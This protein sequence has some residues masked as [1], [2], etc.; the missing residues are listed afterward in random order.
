M[1][2]KLIN[3]FTAVLWAACWSYLPA[4]TQTRYYTQLKIVS[5][6]DRSEQKGDGSG[7]FITFNEKGCYDSDKDGYTVDNG[8]LKLGKRDGDRAYYSG[9]SYWGEATYVFT[10]NYNRLNV[11]VSSSDKI[12]V[13]V[14]STT[15]AGALTCALIRSNDPPGNA[16]VVPVILPVVPPVNGGTVISNNRVTCSKCGGSGVCTSC[17]GS[18]RGMTCGAC[19]GRGKKE[20]FGY[21]VTTWG[22]CTS[23]AG[24]GYSDC[25]SC[26]VRG[27]GKCMQCRG[28]GYN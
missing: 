16:P 12:Y 20:N 26:S 18:G 7:Q 22:T 23:C 28:T 5:A 25:Y 13:Y 2:R 4:Q 8:F 9:N 11:R 27:N 6:D 14:R 3:L 19:N 21:G 10:E 24:K 17:R 1:K 15:P